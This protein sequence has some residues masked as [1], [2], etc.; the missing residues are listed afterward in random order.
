MI[1]PTNVLLNAQPNPAAADATKVAA[2]APS[3]FSKVLGAVKSVFNGTVNAVYSSGSAVKGLGSRAV[4]ACSAHPVA[5]KVGLGGIATLGSLYLANKYCPA[6]QR[7]V[8]KL[9]H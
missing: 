2:Q 1:N 7:L 5:T 8:S 3:Y 9:T 6:F 4:S